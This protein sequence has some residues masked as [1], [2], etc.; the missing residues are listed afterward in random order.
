[1]NKSI[2]KAWNVMSNFAPVQLEKLVSDMDSQERVE[3]ENFLEAIAEK[4]SQYAGYFEM[5]YG[6]GCGDQGHEDAVKRFNRNG[7]MVHC[8][9]F[10]YNAYLPIT[11]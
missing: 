4:A 8:K 11:F 1:M 3:V 5:R 9:T 2:E 10:G 6:H 7:K